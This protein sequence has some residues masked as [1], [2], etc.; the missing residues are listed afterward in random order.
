MDQI[1]TIKSSASVQVSVFCLFGFFFVCLFLGGCCFLAVGVTHLP[2]L[3]VFTMCH[4]KKTPMSC[5]N[6]D[7]S[8]LYPCV[9][10]QVVL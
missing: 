9:P 8:C 7:L 6:G 2:F 5:K 3:S 1:S 4:S 10:F